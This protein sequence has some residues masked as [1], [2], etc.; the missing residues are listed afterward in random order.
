MPLE[1]RAGPG[2]AAFRKWTALS[3]DAVL[4]P[5]TASHP[6]Q[7]LYVKPARSA[8]AHLTPRPSEPA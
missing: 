2:A 8:S 5:V 4:K 1:P 7:A 3:R 6:A